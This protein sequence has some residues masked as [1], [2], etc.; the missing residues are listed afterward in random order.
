[1]IKI[2]LDEIFI[3]LM[4]REI[5]CEYSNRYYPEQSWIEHICDL[6]SVCLF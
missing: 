3:G 4:K 5:S 6:S 2:L 1:M